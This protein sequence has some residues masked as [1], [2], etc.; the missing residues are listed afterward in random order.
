MRQINHYKWMTDGFRWFRLQQAVRETGALASPASSSA[1]RASCSL[2]GAS[3]GRFAGG[4]LLACGVVAGRPAVGSYAAAVRWRA[5]A[6]SGVRGVRPSRRVV[7]AV[8]LAALLVA[9]LPVPAA[10][11][12]ADNAYSD[13]PYT[14]W[15][16]IEERLAGEPYDTINRLREM[17]VFEGTDCGNNKFCPDD[18]VDRKTFAVWLVRVLDGDDSSAQAALSSRPRFGDVPQSDA[19]RKF[20]E[21]LAELEIT[22]GCSLDP[23]LYCPKGTISRGQMATFITKALDLPAAEAIGFW[24]VEKNNRHFDSINSLVGSGIDNGCSEIRFV[25][26]DFCPHQTVSRADLAML[27]SEVI[28]YI[29]ASK[30]FNLAGLKTGGSLGLNVNFSQETF[31]IDVSWNNSSSSKPVSHY[32]LQWKPYWQDF[33]YRRYQVINFKQAGNYR[34]NFSHLKTLYEKTLDKSNATNADL[35]AFRVVVVNANGSE[36]ATNEVR[37]PNRH[38]RLHDNIESLVKRRGQDQPWLVDTWRHLNTPYAG[39][40]FGVDQVSLDSVGGYSHGEL[41]QVFANSLTL[42]SSVEDRQAFDRDIEIVPHELGHVYTLTAGIAKNKA[43]PAIGL[44][45]LENFIRDQSAGCSTEELYADLAVVAFQNSYSEFN[46]SNK[47]LIYWA[48]CSTAFSLTPQD[49]ER[50]VRELREITRSVFVDQKI[51]DWFYDNYRLSDGSIDLDGLWQDISSDLGR[52]RS[53]I[54]YGLKDEF[55]GY[56]SDEEVRRFQIGEITAIKTPWADSGNCQ[57]AKPKPS[58]TTEEPGPQSKTNK[59]NRSTDCSGDIPIIV[60]SDTASQ[61]DRYSAAT[62]AGVLGTDCIILA[63]GRNGPFPADQRARLDSAATAGY[64]VGGTAAVPDAKTAGHSLV[65]IAG[66]DRWHTARLV[67]DQARRIAAS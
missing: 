57:S 20:V 35:Y 67:G 43:A 66:S 15:H 31:D 36:R 56:C 40:G 33:N 62:L 12:E 51:P 9:G 5:V 24:D 64:I 55:G 25:P 49:H 11:Q 47:N 48:G 2:R 61:S 3:A 60:A 7:V 53:L 10:A 54:I 1:P 21:R 26:F 37:V 32:V 23:V 44:L 17:G 8:G 38:H 65:R 58:T 45:Y 6:V 50:V 30:A 4:W 27:L 16:A 59:E 22:N 29:E 18:P 39:V 42:S 41:E 46:L 19:Q 34:V 28:D 52:T 63:G 14:H 13:V